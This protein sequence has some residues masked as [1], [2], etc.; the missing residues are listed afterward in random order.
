MKFLLIDDSEIELYVTSRL[1]D[2]AGLSTSV[3]TFLEAKDALTHL[4]QKKDEKHELPD[5]ILLDIHMPTMSGFDFLDNYIHSLEAVLGHNISV[6]ILSST[7][8]QKDFEKAANYKVVKG[9]FDK[10]LDTVRL[11]NLLESIND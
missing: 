1:L 3:V 9:V 2:N 5:V 8:N 4:I 11:K 7:A 10:P 6:I